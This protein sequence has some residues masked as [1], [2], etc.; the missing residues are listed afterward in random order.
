MAKNKPSEIASTP[1]V[2]QPPVAQDTLALVLQS[3]TLELNVAGNRRMQLSL[4]SVEL[5]VGE[6]NLNL[7]GIKLR[8]GL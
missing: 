2:W 8:I 1:A 7:P 6:F 3:R 4:D 5:G